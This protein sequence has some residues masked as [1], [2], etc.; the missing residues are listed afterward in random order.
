LFFVASIYVI[1]KFQDENSENSE[2]VEGSFIR[3]S[4]GIVTFVPTK[5]LKKKHV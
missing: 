3:N 5:T 4:L 2:D 1:I